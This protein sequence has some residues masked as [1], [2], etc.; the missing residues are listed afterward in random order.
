M[1]AMNVSDFSGLLAD[2]KDGVYN[3]TKD[4][5]C[6]GCGACCSNFLPLSLKEITQIKAYIKKHNIKAQKHSLPTA[7]PVVYD[8]I[9]PFRNNA[10]RKC[11]IYEVRPGICRDFQCNNAQKG[12]FD[13]PTMNDRQYSLIFMR[14]TF[15]EKR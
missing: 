1:N 10:E 3:F 4:G 8:A 6:S 5:K 7:S 9:C 15:F 14:E 12:T 11:M 13:T 2:M